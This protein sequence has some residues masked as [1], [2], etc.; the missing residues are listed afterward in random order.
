MLRR[1]G[2]QRQ[3]VKVQIL[4]RKTDVHF[5]KIENDLSDFLIAIILVQTKAACLQ[6][7]H[8]EFQCARTNGRTST[9][10][11]VCADAFH[12]E[13]MSL[14]TLETSDVLLSRNW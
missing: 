12:F 11:T 10:V 2:G 1:Q 14:L 8:T 3:G 6:K 13:A 9:V 7:V 5:Q 4:P